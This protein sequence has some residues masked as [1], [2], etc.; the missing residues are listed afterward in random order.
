MPGFKK[1]AMSMKAFGG[2]QPQVED[3]IAERF[4]GQVYVENGQLVTH[5]MSEEECERAKRELHTLRETGG[6]SFGSEKVWC[7]ECSGYWLPHEH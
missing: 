4:S 3:Y 5:G 6:S 1:L 2:L 7:D